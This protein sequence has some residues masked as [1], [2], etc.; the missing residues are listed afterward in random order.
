[1]VT[2]RWRHRYI[3]HGVCVVVTVLRQQ[4][5]TECRFSYNEFL[6]GASKSAVYAVAVLLLLWLLML[7]IMMMMMSE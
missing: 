4:R 5:S 1:M 6:I 7:L 2:L 3:P